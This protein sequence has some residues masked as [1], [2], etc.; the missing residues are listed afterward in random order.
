MLCNILQWKARH[1]LCVCENKYACVCVCVGMYVCMY[2]R[3]YVHGLCLRPFECLFLQ[4]FMMRDDACVTVD[5]LRCG[6]HIHPHQL[7]SNPLGAVVESVVSAFDQA[8][9][10]EDRGHWLL[11]GSLT[12][13]L[14]ILFFA[15]V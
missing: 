2:L 15:E 4:Y 6:S 3:V 14:T 1:V 5:G 12:P 10:I 9:A 8:I 13:E 7:L 11:W